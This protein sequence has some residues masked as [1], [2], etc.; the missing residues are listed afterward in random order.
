[1]YIYVIFTPNLG[2]GIVVPG[3]ERKQGRFRE[4]IE[5]EKESIERIKKNI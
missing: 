5:K 4:S 3:R 1:M 2:L